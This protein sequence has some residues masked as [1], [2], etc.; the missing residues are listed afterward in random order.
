MRLY[1]VRHGDVD[2]IYKTHHKP[3][4]AELS[5]SGVKQARLLA[6]RF[7]RLPVDLI[8]ASTYPR[9]KQTALEIEKEIRKKVFYT[10]LIQEKKR[11]TEIEGKPR[12]D[13][14]AVRIKTLIYEHRSDLDWHY[15]DEENFHEF[16]ERCDGFIHYVTKRKE[17]N[18]LIV[19]HEHVIRLILLIIILGI[20]RIDLDLYNERKEILALDYTGIIIL[21]YSNGAWRLITWNDRAHLG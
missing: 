2:A 9:A 18:I 7:R 21:D 15:S 3:P 8:M 14:E 5:P 1:F 13:P 19:S 4:E 20:E 11:P 12:N 10:S 16:K 6:R 17:Q